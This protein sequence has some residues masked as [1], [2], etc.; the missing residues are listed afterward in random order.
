MFKFLSKLIFLVG[1]NTLGLYLAGHFIPG[2][3][4]SQNIGALIA[5]AI[6]LT[7]LNLILRPV[8]KILLI[9]LVLIT[10]GLFNIVISAV[11]LGLLDYISGTIMIS[12]TIP[13]LLAAVLIGIINTLCQRLLLSK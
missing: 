8:L 7:L 3:S 5:L 11:I 2:V 12:G 4:L 9:P 10:F 13:L 1:A 6:V